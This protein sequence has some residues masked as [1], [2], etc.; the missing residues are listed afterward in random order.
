MA[1]SSPTQPSTSATALDLLVAEIR[2]ASA[3]P[4][5]ISVPTWADTYRVLPREAARK[6]GQWETAHVEVARGPMLAVTEPGVRIIT[7]MSCTQLM[8][9]DLLLNVFGYFAHTRPVPILL[10]QPKDDAAERFSKE[11]LT[12]MIRA[13]PVLRELVGTSKMR[14]AGETVDYK[15]FPGGFVGLVGAGSPTD[16]ASRPIGLALADEVDKYPITREGD[17]FT[18]IG[19][20]LATYGAESLFV[21]A[22]SPTVEDESRIADSYAESDQRRPSVACPSCGHRQFLDFFKHVDWP[23]TRD[24]NGAVTGHETRSTHVHCECCG[25]SWSEGERLMALQTIR[26]HQTRPFT[27]CDTRQVPLDEYDR[28]WRL[29]EEPQRPSDD[30]EKPEVVAFEPVD[31]DVALGRVW[32]WW[33]DLEEGRY[34]VY[35]ARCRECG[36]WP[37][38]QRHA[39]FQASKLYSP[40]EADR[41]AVIAEK[42]LHAKGKPELELAW[43]NTQMGLPHKPTAGKVIAVDTLLRRREVYDA[44]LPLQAGLLTCGVD[45]QDYRVEME[46]IAWGLDE[47]SW[48]IDYHVI[49]GEFDS[50]AVQAELDAYLKRRW[51][52]PDGRSFSLAA[53]CIDSG[54]HHTQQVYAFSKARLGRRVWAIKGASES[55]G[56]RN[57]VWPT[58]LPQSKSKSTFKPVMIGGNTARDIVRGRL[59]I[60]PPRV[61]GLPT[62]GFCHFPSDRDVGYFEQLLADRLTVKEVAGR[63]VR[64]WVTPPGR[65]N[66]ASDARVYG[67]A[68]LCGLFHAGLQLN[69]YVRRSIQRAEEEAAE[70]V[71]TTAATQAA[72][73][74]PAAAAAPPPVGTPHRPGKPAAPPG[75]AADRIAALVR[76]MR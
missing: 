17:P 56:V 22:C 58:K 5:R 20:R 47:E 26:W 23:K 18:L 31:S 45:V 57:P 24:E 64:V 48:S 50:P 76:K 65:A 68:A 10:V 67:Y 44:E 32:D 16:L 34:A 15:P 21:R 19:E 4:E 14:S 25:S 73:A 27:C 40:H 1:P 69:R 52:R 38:G 62:P 63:V 7:V 29:L 3:P 43:W 30:G 37:V 55:N 42:W 9:S 39:G 60:D 75:T 53:T 74:T 33:E 66:E 2:A 72:A 46:V 51:M 59:A 11:R 54:G 49:M 13:T 70:A 35:R 28:A 61:P 71:P 6:Y 8:K 41:P 12:P 36:K